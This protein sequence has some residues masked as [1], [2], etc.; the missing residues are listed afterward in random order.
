[1]AYFRMA[2]EARLERVTGTTACAQGH[3]RRA[4]SAGTRAAVWAAARGRP[5]SRNYAEIVTIHAQAHQDSTGRGFYH[6][7]HENLGHHRLAHRR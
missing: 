1:M 2:G 4:S 6:E 7:H 3:A 5:A